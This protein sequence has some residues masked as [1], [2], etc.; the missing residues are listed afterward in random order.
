MII[1]EQHGDLFSAPE[2]VF[3][4]QCISADFGL[5][6]GI[7]VE[8]NNRF[9]IKERIRGAYPIYLA[10][11]RE[12]KKQGD[13]IRIDR[14]F[15]LVTK[16]RYYD[17]PTYQSITEAI[18]KLRKMCDTYQLHKLAMP[19]IG[20]G[21]DRLEWGTVKKILEQEFKGSDMEITVYYI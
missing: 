12:S 7:A 13:C 9:N 1:K 18:K 3:L 5:G 14:V 2:D 20:C 16:E 19:K 6:K 21:L 11:F 17:K 15:N 8:F 10:D 4:V